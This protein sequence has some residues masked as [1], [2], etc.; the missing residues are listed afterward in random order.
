MQ[1]LLSSLTSAS[2]SLLLWSMSGVGNRFP[3]SCVK[4]LV[5][6]QYFSMEGCCPVRKTV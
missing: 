6:I 2:D 5:A 3:G 4:V 1:Q